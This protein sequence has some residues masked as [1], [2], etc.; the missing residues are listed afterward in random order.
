M[1]SWTEQP[2]DR[3]PELRVF[4]PGRRKWDFELYGVAIRR[5]HVR[6]QGGRPVWYGEEADFREASPEERRYGQLRRSRQ[7]S[8]DWRAERE[9]RSPGDFRFDGLRVSDVVAF[10]PHYWQAAQLAA[11]FPYRIY[12]VRAGK[13]GREGT[14]SE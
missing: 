1:V 2:L 5:D 12:L 3:W 8:I 11:E 4:R 13:R 9:W 6:R 10:V 14:R 7:A